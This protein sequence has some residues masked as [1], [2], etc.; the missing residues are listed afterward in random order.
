[1]NKQPSITLEGLSTGY[2]GRWGEH[3]VS[4]QLSASLYRGELTCLL[5]ANGAG[6][7]TLL[8][9]LAGFLPRRSGAITLLDKD[10]SFYKP[11][12]LAQL[13]AV[14]L[15]EKCNLRNMTAFEMVALG[16]SP[17]TGFWGKLMPRDKKIVE[18]SIEA[19]G[20]T[21]LRDRMVQ[22][23]SDGERQ[24]VM[25]AKALAQETPIIFLD[26]PTAFLD[27]PAKVEVMYLLFRLAHT[28]KKSIFLSTHDLELALRIADKIWTLDKKE[29]LRVGT[30]EDLALDGTLSN[31]LAGRGIRFDLQTGLFSIERNTKSTIS[32]IG[33][34]QRASMVQKALSRYNIA[35]RPTSE[36]EVSGEYIKVCPSKFIY[37][38]LNQSEREASNIEALLEIILEK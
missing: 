6:K 28:L 16:R 17:H 35:T 31:F 8:Y 25:I 7:S 18:E 24:K 2:E 4:S 37:G 1:M 30:P 12:Q 27:F 33:D 14:V 10:F 11:K 19:V 15:T 23:L 9:T 5:G 20:I 29:G 21:H 22:T 26:E 36:E 32:L 38:S 13:I 34:G 3:I